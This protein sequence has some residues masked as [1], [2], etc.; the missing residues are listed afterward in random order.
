MNHNLTVFP[1]L[2]GNALCQPQ[3]EFLFVFLHM[4][5][6]SRWPVD[7]YRILLIIPNFLFAHMIQCDSVHVQVK[8]D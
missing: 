3:T 4:R 8:N 5:T 1:E 7:N 6:L 2:R